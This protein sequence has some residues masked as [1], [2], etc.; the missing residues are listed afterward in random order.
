M[1]NVNREEEEEDISTD[2]TGVNVVDNNTTPKQHHQNTA[3][4]TPTTPLKTPQRK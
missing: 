4:K 2:E 3:V 1:S